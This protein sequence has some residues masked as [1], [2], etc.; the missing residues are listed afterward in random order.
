MAFAVEREDAIDARVEDLRK[1]QI[2]W[3]GSCVQ[4]FKCK[5]LDAARAK[6]FESTAG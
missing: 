4:M 2:A 6:E 5:R 1:K 3:Q